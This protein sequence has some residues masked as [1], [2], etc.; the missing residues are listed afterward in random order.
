MSFV[1]ESMKNSIIGTTRGAFGFG[2]DNSKSMETNIK[3]F[4][5]I[6]KC[7]GDIVDGIV[8]E[9]ASVDVSIHQWTSSNIT[10]KLD[11]EANVTSGNVDFDCY[12]IDRKLYIK[13]NTN[14]II[15]NQDLEFD[16][17][18]PPRLFN[19]LTIR[20]DSAD[21]CID[22]GIYARS[23]EVQTIS[24]NIKVG[25]AFVKANLRSKDGD[26]KLSFNAQSKTETKISTVSGDIS[27][28]PSNIRKI[29][30]SAKSKYGEVVNNYHGTYGYVAMINVSSRNGNIIIM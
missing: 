7:D 26:I 3:R 27:I 12:I 28:F 19:S 30:L 24:G 17:W 5:E 15:V 29:S 10:V 2:Q 4:N 13:I 16:V 11:G 23:V 8:I 25:A 21:V 22:K 14:G 18:L 6:Q 1:N 9:T 20:G